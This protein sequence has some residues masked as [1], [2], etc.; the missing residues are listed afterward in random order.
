MSEKHWTEY[1]IAV[2]RDPYCGHIVAAI[3]THC[4]EAAEWIADWRARGERVS[5][6][7]TPTVRLGG[8]TCE[9]PM[10]QLIEEAAR[11]EGA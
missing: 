3:E 2:A 5:F 4:E 11:A 6:T 10:L 9:P 1:R 7:D 8:C